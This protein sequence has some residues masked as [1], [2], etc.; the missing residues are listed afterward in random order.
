MK[1]KKLS[2][3]YCESGRNPA[4]NA[5]RNSETRCSS[6]TSTTKEESFLNSSSTTVL[7]GKALYL[8]K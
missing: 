8:E 7:V 2:L 6:S 3:I 4:A 5:T 1:T